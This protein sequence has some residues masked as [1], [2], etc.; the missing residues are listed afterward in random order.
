MKK[1]LL[2][3]LALLFSTTMFAQLIDEKFDSAELPEGWSIMGEAQKNWSISNANMAGGEANEAKLG[4]YP[5]FSG[6]TRLATKSVDLTDIEGV[7]LTMKLYFENYNQNYKAKFGVA[8]SSDNGTTWNI[9]WEQDYNIVGRYDIEERIATS[10]MGK[11]NVMFCFFFDG[12]SENFTQFCIDNVKITAQSN[13]EIR[14]NSIDI[15]ER[16]GSGP[17]DVK[18]SVQNMGNYN[19]Q[20]FVASY[21][22]D[23]YETVTET[24]S[25]SIPAFG[26]E[27]FTFTDRKNILPGTYNIKID[28]TSVNGGED[29]LN[30]NV[31]TKT[32]NVSLA[33]K[34]RI[35]MIE[36]FSS[37]TCAPCVLINQLMHKMTEENPGK[38]T[39][40]K[41]V[42][43]FPGMGDP[44]YTTESGIRKDYYQ[45]SSVPRCY[46]D[47]ELQVSGNAAQPVTKTKLLNRY[48][49]PAFAEIRGA[50]NM[51][52]NNVIT[53]T[54]DVAS[55]INITDLRTFISVNE[56]TTTKN[57][58][59]YGGNGEKEFHHVMMKMMDG[60]QGI[61]TTINAGDYKRFEFTYDMDSTFMEE[62][63]D[64][65]VAVWV[66][67]PFTKEIINSHYLYEYTNHP[68]PVENLQITEG[69]RL[70]ITWSK[71]ENAEPLGYNLFINNELTLS[72]TKETSFSI[73]KSDFCIVEVVALYE[74]AMT[75]VGAVSIYSSEFA[76]PQNLITTDNT[77]NI[78]VSWDAVENAT[79]Y[80][81][82]RN[83]K[84]LAEVET[85]SYTDGDFL[86]DEE[87]CYQV[88][89]IFGNNKSAFTKEVC[90]TT[91]GDMIEEIGS[92]VEIYPNPV[93]DRLYIEA[94]TE[95][96]EV[97][98]YDVY[99]R[100]QNLRNSET[101]KLRNSIDLSEL[102]SGIYFVKINT[103][104]G[105]IVK[106]IIKG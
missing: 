94:E 37:S 73:D 97:V 84:F 102:K 100:V 53:I 43:N 64:L 17:L 13:S 4:W 3:T 8:T 66:Q 34:Q 5:Q 75:S 71:P 106:R 10:D 88:R 35:P 15:Y 33:E 72:N 22:L 77:S 96:E 78:V 31:M 12:V 26:T 18:F 55:Y 56:K 32:F 79:S 16:I 28:I 91:T 61:E 57:T 95:I 7:T 105:N 101:Q 36:H 24:F 11:D 2:L 50:F 48:E 76:V 21:E 30:D 54:A 45:A 47:S 51:D 90:I 93:N 59:E 49:V 40:T 41:Y 82:Y 69:N 104:E 80:E 62:A 6:V 29:N 83:N 1:T 85:T 103:H 70:K 19:I 99:G 89:A 38:F 42:V 98:I 60:G 67:D 14:L 46:L 65:E 27:T 81:V 44:Y 87:L 68:Y 52:E 9:G 58:V 23:G 39:Y 86:K 25:A 74:N 63:N 20:S 92:K